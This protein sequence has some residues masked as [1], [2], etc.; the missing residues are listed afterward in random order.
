MSLAAQHLHEAVTLLPP[1]IPAIKPIVLWDVSR[2]VPG[3]VRARSVLKV[4]NDKGQTTTRTAA[5]TCC[6][7]RTRN[8]LSQPWEHTLQ[9]P[10]LSGIPIRRNHDSH[11]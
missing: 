11:G 3:Q 8:P 2:R 4:T 10:G 9:A 5:A 1:S 7:R 6:F